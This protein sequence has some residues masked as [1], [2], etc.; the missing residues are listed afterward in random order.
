M[1]P[2]G[3]DLVLVIFG[4]DRRMLDSLVE[5]ASGLMYVH[6]ALG[7]GPEVAPAKNLDAFLIPVMAAERL[8]INP[9]L[10]WNEAVVF[11]T[12][13]ERVAQGLPAY[14]VAGVRTT[15][16][17]PRNWRNELKVFLEA[18]V[19]AIKRFNESADHGI[20]RVGIVVHDLL[21]RRLSAHTIL[22]VIREVFESNRDLNTH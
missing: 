2:R 11:P 10:P 13:A 6:C 8:G 20:H 5:A 3:P 16:E 22:D 14:M 9:L 17:N 1:N 19:R 18:A 7:T 12:P 4:T 21:V 15:L